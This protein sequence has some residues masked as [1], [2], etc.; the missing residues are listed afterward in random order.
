[1]QINLKSNR[2]QIIFA[3]QIIEDELRKKYIRNY[4]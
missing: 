3:Q 4:R 1:M 2:N